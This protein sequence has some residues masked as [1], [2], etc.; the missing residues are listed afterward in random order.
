[1]EF[2]APASA[3]VRVVQIVGNGCVRLTKVRSGSNA[4]F[5]GRPV[6]AQ[7][8]RS[9]RSVPDLAIEFYDYHT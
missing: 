3:T 9:S 5:W 7:S 1:L 4:P 2:L 8:G 6:L